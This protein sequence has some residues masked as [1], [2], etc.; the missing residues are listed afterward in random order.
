MSD[1]PKKAPKKKRKRH[2]KQA[3]KPGKARHRTAK[4]RAKKAKKIA[5]DR[6]RKK[7]K[8]GTMPVARE[9]AILADGHRLAKN[10]EDSASD[11]TERGTKPE[12]KH[13]SKTEPKRDSKTESKRDSKARS[14]KTVSKP[15]SKPASKPDSKPASKRDSKARDPKTASKPESKREKTESKR[16]SKARDSKTASKTASKPESKRENTESKRDSE[17][18]DS[19]TAPKTE[20]KPESKRQSRSAAKRG[21]KSAAKRDSPSTSK[22]E[23]K[24]RTSKRARRT[25][26]TRNDD[27][28]R[29]EPL[30]HQ[31][32]P[33]T[34][35]GEAAL[36]AALGKALEASEGERDD[37]TH[38]FHSYPAR[39]HPQIA[40]RVLESDVLA[41]RRGVVLDPFCGSGT[42]L[43]EAL[44][45]GRPCVGVDLNP[46]AV[47][48]AQ[49]KTQV[50][51]ATSRKRF[52]TALHHVA[53]RS[54]E[55]VRARV[56]ARAPL[57]P[58]EAQWWSGHV[59]KELAGLR[60][61]ILEVE[62]PLDRRTLLV[63]LSAIV[64][65]FSKQRAD[66]SGEMIPRRIRKGL[67]TEF[68]LRRGEELLERW[69]AL[70]DVAPAQPKVTVREGDA[71]E[72]G[73]ITTR[74]PTLVLSSPPYGGTYDYVDHH[75]RRYRWLGVD[76]RTLRAKEVGARR[77]LQGPDAVRLWDRQLLD[78]LRAIRDRLGKGGRVILLVGDAQL[79]ENRID[80]DAQLERLAPQAGLRFAASAS[81]RRP[82]WTGK[83]DRREHLVLLRMK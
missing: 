2:A 60:E 80:A 30:A 51:T 53:T 62:P 33:V 43:V 76:P 56:D 20:S 79:G 50:R 44:A 63:V 21:S 28:A 5:G 11:D 14:S 1:E 48:V 59:L 15:A 65:K 18:R 4:K 61:E 77:D 9:E 37:L 68:F 42:V 19:K 74:R 49:V 17:A 64:T 81:Q 57:P 36:A 35:R 66:T 3:S 52:R 46:V 26:S 34:T 39:M 8:R 69:E 58:Q 41:D 13:D 25:E 54:E 29:R 45:A 75:A 78:V 70:A 27:P 82:D 55:R 23:P 73:R 24:R 40:R 38:G 7:K 22:N 47:R 10:A 71:R 31:G 83:D 12:P 16:D 67:P 6:A 72:L 32:G